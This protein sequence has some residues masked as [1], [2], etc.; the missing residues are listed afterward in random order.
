MNEFGTLH[1]VRTEYICGLFEVRICDVLKMVA[2]VGP[3]RTGSESQ[4]IT[5]PEVEKLR[6]Y[7]IDRT[8]HRYELLGYQVDV[9]GVARNAVA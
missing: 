9:S 4:R 2:V 1:D 3:K 6:Q 7:A 5:D 8:K